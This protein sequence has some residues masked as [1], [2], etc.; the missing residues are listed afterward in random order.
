MRIFQSENTQKRFNKIQS[1]FKSNN[2]IEVKLQNFYFVRKKPSSIIGHRKLEIESPYLQKLSHSNFLNAIYST[3][4]R[5]NTNLT[6]SNLNS[7]RTAKT[8]SRANSALA[9]RPASSQL[10]N[11]KFEAYSRNN[12]T[13]SGIFLNTNNRLQLEN[14]SL[15]RERPSS[16]PVKR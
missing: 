1:K 7:V 12:E 13:S 8:N 9:Q 15:R 14:L 6:T 2:K 5:F 4:S 3:N 11:H 16:A 10:I